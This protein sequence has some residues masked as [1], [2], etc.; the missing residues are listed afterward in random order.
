[1]TTLE[2]PAG[3]WAITNGRIVLPQAIVT[4][5]AVVVEGD[6]IVGI[7]P[8]DSLGRDLVRVDAGERIITPGL[9]DLHTHGALG[10][11]LQRYGCA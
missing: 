9:I 5:Q 10:Q 7:A 4:G 11:C 8:S 3:R 2:Q 1:M 6:K